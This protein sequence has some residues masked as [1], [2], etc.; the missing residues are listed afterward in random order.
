MAFNPLREI[1]FGRPP[2]RGIST[3]VVTTVLTI[4]VASII[5]GSIKE[6]IS[7]NFQKKHKGDT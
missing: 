4:V 3:G 1:I 2:V 6:M 5:L 7:N